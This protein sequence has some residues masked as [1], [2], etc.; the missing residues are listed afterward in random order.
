M[1]A[2]LIAFPNYLPYFNESV[3]GSSQGYRYLADCNVDW[4]Q[5]LKALGEYLQ[6]RNIQGIALSYF[7]SADPH[8]YGVRY[9]P[10]ASVTSVPFPGD[11]SAAVQNQKTFLFAISATNRVGLYHKDHHLFEW[12]NAYHPA[13]QIA[14]SIFVYDFTQD[15]QAQQH[16]E[17]I[18]RTPS[19]WTE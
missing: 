19:I 13:A 15:L 17:Q 4:G 11:G 3:G 10:V 8:S 5:G 12:L 16:L 18:R 2:A 9:L 6:K 7:G 1:A 14:Q